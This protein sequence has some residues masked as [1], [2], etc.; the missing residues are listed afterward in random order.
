MG[1]ARPYAELV[2]VAIFAYIA[3]SS[4]RIVISHLLDRYAPNSIGADVLV[5]AG[6]TVLAVA[7]LS[8]VVP[9][10]R[11]DSDDPDASDREN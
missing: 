7:I 5:A 6:A 9:R 11:V 1:R 10:G 4:W 3:A 8:R 2:A